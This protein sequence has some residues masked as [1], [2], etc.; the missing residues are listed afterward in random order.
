MLNAETKSIPQKQLQLLPE[1]EGFFS[2]EWQPF[3]DLADGCLGKIRTVK[4]VKDKQNLI[5]ALSEGWIG[6]VPT[7]GHRVL[8]GK[9]RS[10]EGRGYA[11]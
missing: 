6:L 9:T 1:I 7:D 2:K 4:L 11:P 5:H 10:I 3:F 8:V